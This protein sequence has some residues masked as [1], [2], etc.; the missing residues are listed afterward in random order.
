MYEIF[1]RFA[2]DYGDAKAYAVELLNLLPQPVK[3]APVWFDKMTKLWRYEY[4]LPYDRLPELTLISGTNVHLP[5][6]ELYSALRI[7][8]KRLKRDQLRTFLK[9]LSDSGKHSDVLFEMRPIRDVSAKLQAD[10]EVSGLGIG[11]TTCDWQVKGRF[12]NVV[13]DVKNRTKSFIEHMKQIIPDLNKGVANIQ[14]TAPNPEDLFKSVEN[15]LEERCYFSQLQGVWIH[16][17][18]KEDEEKL[19]LYFKNTLNRKKVH[20]AILSDWENDAFIL[21]RSNII[22]NALKR[23]FRLTKSARFVSR[24][25]A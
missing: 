13:F 23:I 1:T 24:Q 17:D 20:F 10:Y 18:I 12:I 8:D 9:R 7:A 14:P 21:A 5:V 6:D 2:P 11:N 15:K 4:G 16:S 19:T 3:E 22:E 25:Y